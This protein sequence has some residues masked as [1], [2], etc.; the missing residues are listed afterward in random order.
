MTSLLTVALAQALIAMTLANPAPPIPLETGWRMQSSAELSAKGEALS[1][2]EY[3]DADWYE[4][5]VPKTVLAGLV[6]NGV[7]PDPYYGENLKSIPGYQDGLWLIQKEDSPFRSSWWYRVDFNLPEKG[8]DRCYTLHFEG[9]NYEANIWLNGRQIADH[10]DVVGMFRR[11][12]FHVNDALV[13]GG[14]NAL[15]VEIIPPG[16]MP[17]LE[18]R[19]KQVEA[20]TGWDDHNP[21]PPD[22]NMGLWQ[23]VYL[24][25]QGPISI[26]HPYVETELSLPGLEQARLR[27]SAWL[28][29]NTDAP[30]VGVLSGTIEDRAFS[31][32]VALEANETREFFF[33]PDAFASL[34]VD[35]PRVWWPHPVGA[36]ELY[37]LE[38]TAAVGDVVSDT[39]ETNFGI[40]DA[41]TYIN[42]DDW[43]GYQ[44]NGRN[45]LI[46]GGAWMTSDMLLNLDPARYEALVR[47][48]REANLNML[49]SEGFSIRETNTFY[50]LCDRLG[51]MATQQIF[52][53]SIPDEALAVACIEDTLLRIRNHP[54]LVHFLGHDETFPTDSLD[55]AYRELLEKHRL[56]RSYQP[57]SGTFNISTRAKTGG[58]RTG[59]RELW[60][61]A[62]PAH[63]HYMNERK[64]DTAWGFAQSGGIGGILAA[65]D[66]IRQMM[67][68]T[69]LWPLKDNE[70]FSFHPVL[71]GMDYFDAVFKV[72][73]K[74]YGAP[75]DFDGFCDTLYAMNYNSARG[76]YEAY[77]RH[78][79]DALGI[80]T[81]KYNAAWPAALTWQ[82]VD[83]YARPS[84]AYFGAKKACT[85]VHALYGYDD[86]GLYVVNGLYEPQNDLLLT[87][88]FYNLDGT[89]VAEESV[90]LSVES[91]GRVRAADAAPPE[92]VS[93][94]YFLK[95]SLRNADGVL[96]SNNA[97]WLSRTPD[98]PGVSGDRDDVFQIRFKSEADYTALRG[99]PQVDLDAS[100][101]FQDKEAAVSLTNPSEHVAFMV[102]LALIDPNQSLELAPTYWSDNFLTLFPG[103]TREVAAV[104]SKMPETAPLLR[105]Q[106]FNIA[107]EAVAK[108]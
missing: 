86:A 32:P 36:Q 5:S 38:L 15:A 47:H 43:R 100:W 31:Q 13:F 6:D 18:H 107:A 20:T 52:G 102:E 77:A 108:Q 66:S 34:V 45:I 59:S 56:R 79:Y 76:M 58:T 90:A 50:D 98:I 54:S 92:T 9:I 78:K 49:R 44:I 69:A 65:R 70:V 84:A 8:A 91:D 27:V 85:P 24:Y 3:D 12:E 89:K 63:Y 60:T 25:E 73:E 46:R 4:T 17:A 14:A 74:Q 75:T 29:N 68:E 62:S 40:R 101:S 88:A 99:L 16:L 42:E 61:Y 19:T 48:A 28:R 55:A 83:W 93:D 2:P 105:V 87:H 7:Y 41:A 80:T 97:Y 53:R 64:F 39:A 95:L 106:G 35:A 96:I 71:Q 37:A 26:R 22:M 51:V 67:P 21:Q 72:M 11:F 10:K 1:L 23:P 82:Y 104:L 30:V 103:E 94:P 33:E 81:W 57:H